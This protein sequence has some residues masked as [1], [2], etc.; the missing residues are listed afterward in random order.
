MTKCDKCKDPKYLAT[1]EELCEHDPET[2]R[3]QMLTAEFFKVYPRI[4]G[5]PKSN[6]YPEI[7]GK[8]W[9][10]TVRSRKKYNKTLPCLLFQPFLYHTSHFRIVH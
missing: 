8:I 7:S 1:L 6:V 10:F 4:L 5:Y 3:Y 2:Q 9:M